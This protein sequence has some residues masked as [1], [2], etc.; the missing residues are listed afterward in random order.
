LEMHIPPKG[1]TKSL[2]INDLSGLA[3]ARQ[4]LRV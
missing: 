1:L 2:R 4:G 3:G